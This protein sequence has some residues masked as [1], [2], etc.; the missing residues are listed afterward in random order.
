MC[1]GYMHDLLKFNLLLSLVFHKVSYHSSS[2][3]KWDDVSGNKRVLFA[4]L[5]LQSLSDA[6]QNDC[7]EKHANKGLQ[8]QCINMQKKIAMY[9]IAFQ[10]WMKNTCKMIKI[11]SFC[12]NFIFIVRF[13]GSKS[14]QVLTNSGIFFSKNHFSTLAVSK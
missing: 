13:L 1:N 3:C 12:S 10:R 14:N 8:S 7:K 11:S 4:R 6:S 2:V 9:C 5:S